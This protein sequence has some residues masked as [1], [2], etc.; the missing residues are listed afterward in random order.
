M[1]PLIS[2][3]IPTFN[4]AHLI[5]ETI[6]SIQKQSYPN[7]ECII[8][9]DFSTDDSDNIIKKLIK[10]DSRIKFFKKTK[11]KNKGAPAARNY[12]FSKSKGDYINWFDSDDLMHPKKLEIDLKLISSGD[13]DFTISQSVFFKEQAKPSKNMWNETLWSQDP[14]NDFILFKI[15]WGINSPL[16][17]KESLKRCKL[18]FNEQLITANDYLYHIQALQFGLKPISN[19]KTLVYQREHINQLKNYRF[20]SPSKL[21]VNYYLYK[22]QKDLQ[23]NTEVLCFLNRQYVNQFS[24]VLKNKELML[25]ASFLYKSWHINY[26]FK[27]KIKLYQ[28]LVIGMFY[29]VFNKGYNKLN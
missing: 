27:T 29:K 9:D 24:N 5:V 20:K 7:W 17:K 23:L 16:W 19:N 6:E 22:N 11:N 13:F 26:Y 4:R 28:L 18:Q 10:K 3:V 25:A 8:I 15:G 2:I 21:R 1:N 12:G 14:I